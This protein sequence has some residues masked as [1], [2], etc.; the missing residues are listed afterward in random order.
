MPNATAPAQASGYTLVIKDT[1]QEG[2]DPP[3]QEFSSTDGPNGTY[4]PPESF[5]YC[6]M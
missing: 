6:G 5:F 2:G 3:S 1:A 4:S